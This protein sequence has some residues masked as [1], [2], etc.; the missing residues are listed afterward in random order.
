MR[1]PVILLFLLT[2]LAARSQQPD[3]VRALI[4]ST[5]NVMEHRALHGAAINW[6]ALRDSV[7]RKAAGA[8]SDT[9]AAPALFWAF[10]QLQDKHGWI[11][12]ADS[13]HY[14]ENI[15]REKRALNPGLL[16]ALRKGPRLYNGKLE[17]K[18]A[19]I[20]IHYFRDQTEE[21]MNAYAQQIQ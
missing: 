14:N 11:T 5:L 10:D 3:S 8:Q 4:D 12:I 7:R 2:S 21:T 6:P 1:I 15:R 19:Y 9:A 17:G 13:T 18:Y 20:N 16:A